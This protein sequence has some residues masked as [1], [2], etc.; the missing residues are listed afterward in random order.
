MKIKKTRFVLPLLLIAPLFGCGSDGSIGM[1]ESKAW[2]QTASV[3]VKRNYFAAICRGFG[4]TDGSQQM[5]SCIEKQ[6]SESL[7]SRRNSS[8]KVQYKSPP[9]YSPNI[10]CTTVRQTTFCS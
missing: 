7:E 8:S 1:P 2:H 4:Y 10:T 6:W 5:N 9:V 3:E